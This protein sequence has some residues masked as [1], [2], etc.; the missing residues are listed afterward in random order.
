MAQ[1][2]RPG[3]VT[4][5]GAPAKDKD[6]PAPGPIDPASGQHTDYWVLSEEERAK[7][8]V[9]PVRLAYRHDGPAK[10]G[11]LRDLTDE[12]AERF[13]GCGYVKFEAYLPS[14][15]PAIGKYWMQ[16]HLDRL[17]TGCG[18]V[19]TMALPLAETYARD[20]GF[21]GST[22]CCHCGKHFPV[23]EFTWDGVDEKVG[24]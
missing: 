6:G 16:A 12:E 1:D 3:R 14:K 4:L 24:S 15:S 23:A 2:D 8:L 11:T 17:D 10:P 9:R 7:G 22:F 19:T 20:P 5:S 18:G 21:Y 13:A